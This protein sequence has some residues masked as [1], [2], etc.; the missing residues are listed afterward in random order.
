MTDVQRLHQSLTSGALKS[1]LRTVQESI[2]IAR[3]MA[4][5]IEAAGIKAGDYH[6]HLAYMTPDLSSLFTHRFE[7]G[8]EAKIQENL[9]GTGNCCIMVGIVFGIKDAEK[10]GL[11]LFGARPFLNT[12]L[13]LMALKQRLED[14]TSG[15]N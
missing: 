6:V 15:I 9:S 7:R 13:V 8:L 12:P 3:A 1:E 2:H 10:G 14:T 11:W 4:A 5:Q